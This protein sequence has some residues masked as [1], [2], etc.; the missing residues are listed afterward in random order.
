VKSKI[1]KPKS[2]ESPND[3]T[4]NPKALNHA[5]C[6]APSDAQDRHS[7]LEVSVF[8]VSLDFGFWILDLPRPI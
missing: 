3:E 7:G 2:K 1:Q 8:G 4:L 6:G 5:G